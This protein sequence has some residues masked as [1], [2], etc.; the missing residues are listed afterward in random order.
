MLRMVRQ[1][2][3]SKRRIRFE[4]L[5]TWGRCPQ[6]P[7]ERTKGGRMKKFRV[8]FEFLNNNNEWVEDDLSNNGAGFTTEEAENVLQQ[9]KYDEVC[10]KR[11]LRIETI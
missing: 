6:E 4:H 11:K 7:K 2:A 3:R 9:L 5:T 8:V 1:E 10:I